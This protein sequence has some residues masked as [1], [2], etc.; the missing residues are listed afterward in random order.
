MWETETLNWAQFM[1]QWLSVSLNSMNSVKVMLHLGK[2]LID[3]NFSYYTLIT[4]TNSPVRFTS[5]LCDVG[6][7]T[8]YGTC[9]IVTTNANVNWSTNNQSINQSSVSWY[10]FRVVSGNRYLSRGSNENVLYITRTG[11]VFVAR[12]V[13][14]L[15][16][17]RTTVILN[18][19]LWG[20]FH[21][22]KF[23]YWF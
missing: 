22:S 15:H 14:H 16:P 5:V 4:T 2:T 23:I 17:A 12:W 10:L 9:T 6:V 1:L 20:I 18:F 8:K 19:F 21:L 13:I 3:T 7:D 11:N